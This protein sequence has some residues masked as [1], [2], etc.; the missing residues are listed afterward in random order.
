M[1]GSPLALINS[2]HRVGEKIAGRVVHL[3]HPLHS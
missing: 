2:L 3:A 1:S